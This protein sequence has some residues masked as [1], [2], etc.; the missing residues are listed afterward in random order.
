MRLITT[1]LVVVFGLS[2][3]AAVIQAQSPAAPAAPATDQK[4]PDSQATPAAPAPE[5]KPPDAQ[6]TPA[7][8][9]KEFFCEKCG[10]VANEPGTCPKD[11]ETLKEKLPASP[12]PAASPAPGATGHEATEHQGDKK[13]GEGEHKEKHEEGEHH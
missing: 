1:V 9:K 6:P 4:A 2:C 10:Y 11:G 3:A 13:P 5:Q 12:A 7:A 8:E